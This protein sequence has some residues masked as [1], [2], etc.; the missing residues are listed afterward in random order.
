MSSCSSCTFLFLFSFL[1]S[2]GAS[3]QNPQN[4]QNPY[5]LDLFC[6][7]TTRNS[8]YFTSNR[9]NVLSSLRDASYYTGFQNATAGQAPNKVN[10]L[11]LCRGDVL[12]EVCR[13][14]VTYSVNQIL[15]RCPNGNEAVIYFEECILRYSHKNIFS[16]LTLEG[17]HIRMNGNNIS[18]SQEVR[19][20]GQVSF[21]LNL[22]ASEAANNSRKFYTTKANFTKVQTLYVLAQC[23]PDLTRQDCLTCLRSSINGMPLN[24]YGGRLLWPSCNTRYELNLFYNETANRTSPPR[25]GKLPFLC[26]FYSSRISNISLPGKDGNSNVLAVTVVVPIVVIVLLFGAC[27]CFIAKRAK[28]TSDSAPASSTGDGITTIESLQLDYRTIQAATDNF[29]EN[30]KIGRGGFGEVYKG[31]FSNGTEVAAKKLSKSSGQGDLEFMN[32]VVVVAKLQHRNLVRLL[33]FSLNRKERILVYE[34]VPNK[35]LDYF[36]FD[37]AKQGQ[38]DWPRRFTIIEGIAR[39]ILYLHQDSRITI[40]HRDLKASNVLLDADM[41]PKVADFGMAK[42]FGIDQTQ[43]NTSRIVGTF[44]YMSPEYAMHGHFSMKSD[45]YSFGVLVLEIISGKKNSK[46]YEIDGGHDLVTYVWRLW[47]NGTTLDIVD[48]VILDNFQKSEVLR[49]I[50][51][52]LLCVQEDH[53]VR[54]TMRTILMMLTSNT[55]TLPVPRQPGFFVQNRPQKDP[56]DSDQSRTSNSVPA[57]SFD[58]ASVTEVSPR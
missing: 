48:P 34:Y 29:S 21:M 51:I 25:S 56:L 27:Y 35:S 20:R 32:E 12:Q 50:H 37:T 7:N 10:G 43:G 31:T 30:N 47:S 24:R 8:T 52:G 49:C 11:F 26:L 58:D 53:I 3:A 18:L 46:F 14:C 39:G 57:G 28:Q 15:A 22:A 23:T 44:G 9:E 16:V 33:G 42:I 4:P 54:P 36:L 55:V 6:P 19:F 40:I 45:V 38:L 5:F 17:E 2:Y 13:N 41:N 1:T